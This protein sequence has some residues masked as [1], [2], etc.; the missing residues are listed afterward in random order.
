MTVA[1]LC[2]VQDL[3]QSSRRRKHLIC[4]QPLLKGS[5][6][7]LNGARCDWSA[8]P[9]QACRHG[10]TWSRSQRPLKLA[11]VPS[12]S[13]AKSGDACGVTVFASLPELQRT[14]SIGSVAAMEAYDGTHSFYPPHLLDYDAT[15]GLHPPDF[16]SGGDQPLNIDLDSFAG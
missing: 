11:L 16:D 4:R 8:H 14:F 9:S 1:P 15:A 2:H 12:Q 3:E 5:E 7:L 6:H 13:L 10:R